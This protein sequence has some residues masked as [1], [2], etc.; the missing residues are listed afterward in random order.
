M[1]RGVPV[2]ATRVGGVPDVLGEDEGWLIPSENPQAMANAIGQVITQPA[3]TAGRTSRARVR[4]NRD[5][6][7]GPWIERHAELYQNLLL[8]RN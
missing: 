2:V 5:H 3:M 6:A 8:K 7:A 4:V 1:A